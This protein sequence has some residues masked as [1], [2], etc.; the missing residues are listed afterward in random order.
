MLGG[1]NVV[2]FIL[3]RWLLARF[4]RVARGHTRLRRYARALACVLLSIS[5]PRVQRRG[6]RPEDVASSLPNGHQPQF[7]GVEH[8]HLEFPRQT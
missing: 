7:G 1:F 8:L 5:L 4:F 2:S 6:V 3:L